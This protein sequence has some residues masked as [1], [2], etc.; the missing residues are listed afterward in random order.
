MSTHV[1]D[2]KGCGRPDIIAK[3]LNG[4]AKEVDKLKIQESSFEHCGIKHRQDKEGSIFITQEHYI[5]QLSP[6]CRRAELTF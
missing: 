3:I 5:Q 2:I 1:D 6:Y 4:L